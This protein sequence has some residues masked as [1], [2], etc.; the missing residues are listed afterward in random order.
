MPS[1]IHDLPSLEELGRDLL[2]VS[3]GRRAL[4]LALPFALA[5]LFFLIA[6]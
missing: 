6:G 3:P 2:H 1:S 4:S 5:A